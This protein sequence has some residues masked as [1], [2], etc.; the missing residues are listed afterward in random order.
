LVAVLPGGTPEIFPIPIKMLRSLPDVG[1]RVMSTAL[2]TKSPTPSVEHFAGSALRPDGSPFYLTTLAPSLHEALAHPWRGAFYAPFGVGEVLGTVVGDPS[3]THIVTITVNAELR[4][5]G[6][7]HARVEWVLIGPKNTTA[8]KAA[9]I[10]SI[11]ITNPG[12]HNPEDIRRCI[13]LHGP[14][15]SRGEPKAIVAMQCGVA[16]ACLIEA[17]C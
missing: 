11:N 14:Q 8:N 13:A 1:L 5:E 6:K 15:R 7:E 3:A 2:G 9:L 17:I 12:P 16:A 10:K 4:V